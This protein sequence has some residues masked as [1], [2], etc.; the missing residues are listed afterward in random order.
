MKWVVGNWKMHTT[1]QEAKLLARRLREELYEPEL[2]RRVRVILC[3]PFTSL[4][5]VRDALRGSWL[6]WGAQNC[7]E[8]LEGAFTGEISVRM[9]TALGC[10][11]VIVGHSERRRDAGESTERIARKLRRVL[12]S[13]LW[14]I[15]CVGET[16]AQRRARRIRAVLKYQLYS[17]LQGLEPQQWE[18]L[19]VA[20]EPV[21]AIGTGQAAK[22]EHIRQAHALVAELLAHLGAPGHVPILYGGSVTAENAQQILQLPEVDGVLVGSA[23]LD[24]WQFCTIVR[25][26]ALCTSPVQIC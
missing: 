4:C 8:E 17:A 21:W 20:Y 3:P 10:S 12:Q 25:V 11:A 16:L 9:L 26:A 23:S 2:P 13:G 5:S 22:P 6:Q 15:L 7:H 14:A 24:A 1:A 19:L 18:S